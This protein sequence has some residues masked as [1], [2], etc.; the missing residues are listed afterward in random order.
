M[1]LEIRSEHTRRPN[2]HTNPSKY[3][4]GRKGRFQFIHKKK[5][6]TRELLKVVLS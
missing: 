6:E 1:T 2:R 3:G 5:R 4:K